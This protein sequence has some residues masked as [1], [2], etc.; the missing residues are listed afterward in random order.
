MKRYGI[1]LIILLISFVLGAYATYIS[2]NY[3]ANPP[4][5]SD[6]TARFNELKTSVLVAVISSFIGIIGTLIFLVEFMKHDHG[7]SPTKVSAPPP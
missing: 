4:S 7:I 6:E 1:G 2:Y 5:A 3:I